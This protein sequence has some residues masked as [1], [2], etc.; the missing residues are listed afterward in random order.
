[1]QRLAETPVS[2]SDD[3]AGRLDS[4]AKKDDGPGQETASALGIPKRDFDGGLLERW[5]FTLTRADALA[6][7]RLRREWSD[8]AK[9]LLPGDLLWAFLAVEAALIAAIFAGRDLVRRRRA[10]RLVPVP[11]PAVLEEWTD[12]IA[13]TEIGSA[14]EAYLSP[15]LIGEVLLTPTHLFI[16]GFDTVIAVPRTAF[17]DAEEAEAT[18]AHFKSLARGPYYFEA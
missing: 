14:D 12:C 15:E 2:L 8:R 6:Y 1:V 18:A 11:R 5:Q 7:L 4:L 16:L 13:G 9:G 3:A 10:F 17:A